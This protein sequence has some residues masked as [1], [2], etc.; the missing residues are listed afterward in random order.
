MDRASSGDD[1]LSMDK[2]GQAAGAGPLFHVL[3]Q[4]TEQ[5]DMVAGVAAIEAGRRICIVL[6]SV[7][8][9]CLLCAATRAWGSRMM[10]S[11]SMPYAMA[12]EPMDS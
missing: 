10:I 3:D 6:V 7:G 8:H 4:D 5:S 1:A 11:G 12:P 2:V 9:S